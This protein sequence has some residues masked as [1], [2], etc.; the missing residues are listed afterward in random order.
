MLWPSSEKCQSGRDTSKT[1]LWRVASQHPH[2]HN[3]QLQK[4][5]TS[6]FFQPRAGPAHTAE[7]TLTRG[8]QGAAVGARWPGDRT[9]VTCVVSRCTKPFC[10]L[11]HFLCSIQAAVVVSLLQAQPR[12]KPSRT[13]CWLPIDSIKREPNQRVSTRRGPLRSIQ[14]CCS[15]AGQQLCSNQKNRPL[16]LQL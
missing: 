16:R 14:V 15:A 1:R 2:A 4:K 7:S 11:T 3:K 9:L 13:G 10:H 6:A 5:S 12:A 8:Q